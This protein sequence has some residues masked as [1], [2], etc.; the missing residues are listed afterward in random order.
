MAKKSTTKKAKFQTEVFNPKAPAY[1][2]RTF[3]GSGREWLP[4]QSFDWGALSISQRRVSQ[5]FQQ[6]Y[7]TH[8]EPEFTPED[9]AADKTIDETNKGDLQGGIEEKKQPDE[10]ADGAKIVKKP[11]GWYDVVDVEGKVVNPKSLR[12]PEAEEL[13]ASLTTKQ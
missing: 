2:R 11:G 8:E 10:K 13:L 3:R 12:E 9:E 1:V 7:L 6:R 4:G 5:L